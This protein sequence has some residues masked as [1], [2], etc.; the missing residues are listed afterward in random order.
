MSTISTHLNWGASYIVN[1]FYVRFI[2]PSASQKKQ[3]NSGRIATVGLM[4]LSAIMA[5][6]LTNA[7]QAFN[8]LLQIGAGTGLLFIL[9][10]FWWRINAY[11]EI[12]A[13]IVSFLIALYFEL[14]YDGPMEDYQEM[15]TGVG[16]TTVAWVITTFITRPTEMTRLKSFFQL[17]RPH[18]AGWQPVVSELNSEGIHV[19]HAGRSFSSELLMLFLGCVMI[20]AAL[21]GIGY[22]LYGRI[23][24]AGIFT[25]LA[26]LSGVWIGKLWK[27]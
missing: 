19:A 4:I 18:D 7:M 13:M 1:D 12:V 24:W 22:L 15:V 9:R 3:V 21:F 5:L 8:I 11:S 27:S 25:V 16:I 17:I 10:W 6:Y 20:Y 23:L 2:N 26:I 14:G